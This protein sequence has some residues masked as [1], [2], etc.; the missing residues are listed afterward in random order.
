MWNKK[1]SR[2]I[3]EIEKWKEEMESSFDKKIKVYINQAL[4]RACKLERHELAFEF[5]SKG[6]QIY[7]ESFEVSKANK[8]LLEN[9]YDQRHLEIFR[10]T[11][12]SSYLLANFCYKYKRYQKTNK[13]SWPT[14]FENITTP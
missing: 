7:R 12:S 10:A 2:L 9:Q 5:L 3:E 14:T 1:I 4:V 13:G 8:S 6:F 11:S